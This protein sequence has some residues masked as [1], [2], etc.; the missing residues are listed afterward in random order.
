[1]PLPHFEGGSVIKLPFAGTA[2]AT[3]R[4]PR[5]TSDRN[6]SGLPVTVRKWK[7]AFAA[8]PK[9]AKLN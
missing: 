7:A 3:H 5:P 1:M 4:S 9:S 6:P 8:L 2:S